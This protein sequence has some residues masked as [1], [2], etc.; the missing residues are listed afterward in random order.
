MGMREIWSRL[1]LWAGRETME[2]EMDEEMRFHIEQA[3]GKNIRAGMAP[4]EARRTALVA[5]GGMERFKE[6][7]REES[8]PRLLEELVQDLRYGLR[9]LGR[10]SGFTIVAVLTLGLGIGANTAIFSV[11]DGVLLRPVPLE[12]ADRLMMVWETDRDSGTTREP[13]SVPDF[14]DFRERS[15]R[16]ETLAAFSGAEVNL[17]PDDGEPTRLAALAVGHTFLP[18]AGIRPLLGRGFE[19]ADD[20]PGAPGVVLIGEGLWERLFGRDPSAVG[21]TVRLDDEPYTV[22]GVLSDDA[23][24]GSLQILSAAD[25]SRSFADRDRGT[26]VEVWVPLRPDPE[27]LPRSTHP[28]FVLGRLAPGAT[29]EDAQQEMSAI[30]AELEQTYPENAARGVFLEP[31]PEVVFGPVRPALL[32]L[33]GAVALVLLAACANIAN[34]LVARGAVR[35]REVAVRTA[36]GAGWRRLMRQFLVESALLTLAGV[37]LGLLLAFLGLDLLL[38]L[39]PGGIPRLSEVEI[40]ARVLGITLMIAALVALAMGLAPAFYARRA[41]LQATLKEEAGRSATADRVR[42]RLR[43]L[44]V[45]GELALAVVLLVG[46]GLLLKSFWLLQRVD[47][48]FR[49]SGVLKAELQLPASRYPREFSTWPNWKEHH[50]FNAEL[51]DRV[52]ALPGVESAAVAGN[53]PLDAGFTNSFYVVG[54][55]EEARDWPEIAIRRVSPGYFQTVGMSLVRGRLFR[56]ADDAAAAPALLV[57]E[58]AARQFFRGQDPLGQKISF[59]GAERTIVGIVSNERFHGLTETAPPAVYAPLA[60]V[61]SVTGSTSLLVRVEGDPAAL[62]ADVRAAIREID[63]ALAVFGMEPLE[64][65]LADSVG[66]QRFTMLLVTVFAGLALVL[67]I[68]GVYGVL[69]YM[70]A[71][72]APEMG[73]RMALGATQENVVRLIVLQGARLALVGLALGLAGGL[74]ATRFLQSL[75]FGVGTTDPLTFVAVLALVF[76]AA[77]LA[78]WLPAH[79]ATRSDPMLALRAS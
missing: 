7:S 56:D 15:T 58:E 78:S 47:P 73:I 23:D 44:L 51:L 46:A 79:R 39:A 10:N 29:P 12:Q 54:R 6:E 24:F 52:R 31:F 70:V 4:E 34:L 32:V 16:F 66:Q 2:R 40:D 55:Q 25:Y 42:S 68:V 63:P 3:T 37:G 62:A 18:M 21:R 71:Q 35:L 20:R 59:W 41:D 50:R 9:T 67:A 61:P 75:L 1:R 30:A 45:I 74:A 38:A 72:R 69:S 76:A 48:G 19:E 49:A 60:Q 53:H 14:L 57:N 43:S 27:A 26:E 64:R 8:R 17:T 36:L 77:L 33:L 11:V 65:T 28:I 22:V 13:A 5:F